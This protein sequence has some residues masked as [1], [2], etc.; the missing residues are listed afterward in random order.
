ML[1]ERER[2]VLARIEASLKETDPDLV[3]LF[4]E[5]ALRPTVHGLPRTL[6]VFGLVMVVL[7]ALVAAVPVAMFGMA[8][9]VAA[10]WLAWTR[11]P[12]LGR[13]RLA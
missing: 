11:S 13:P 4:H 2:R 6:L 10:L 3:R 1:S 8:L 5:G 9:T 7:G 12:G